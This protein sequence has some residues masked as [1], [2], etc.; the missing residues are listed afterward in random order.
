MIP[1]GKYNDGDRLTPSEAAEF[2]GYKGKQTLANLRMKNQGPAYE[3][4]S[5]KKIFY[6]VADLK[7]WRE[8]RRFVPGESRAV[9]EAR[10][11][12]SRAGA[13]KSAG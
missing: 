9:R 3:K 6:R 13:H 12:L 10:Q 2:L 11:R 7:D 4:P 1:D 8:R 5:P